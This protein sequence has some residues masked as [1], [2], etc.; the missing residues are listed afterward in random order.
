[1]M[2]IIY[3]VLLL[4]SIANLVSIQL[5]GIEGNAYYTGMKTV[6]I[7]VLVNL[8]V[9]IVQNI[10]NSKGKRNEIVG[11]FTLFLLAY[12]CVHFQTFT[13]LM[14][15]EDY[16]DRFNVYNDKY[17]NLRTAIISIIGLE[18]LLLGNSIALHRKTVSKLYGIKV[19]VSEGKKL[20]K[21]I[22]FFLF[23]S[24][25][26]FTYL[27][28]RQ[29]FEGV[30]S[31]EMLDNMSGTMNAYSGILVE[32]LFYSAVLFKI[33]SIRESVP[34]YFTFV[35]YLKSFSFLFYLS[36]LI[37]LVLVFIYGDR[38]PIISFVLS[39]G[40][41]YIMIS[42]HR[43]SWVTL[44]TFFVIGGMFLS[45]MGIARADRM[46]GSY[47]LQNT[48]N[49]IKTILDLKSVF[50]FT[51]ELAGSNRT[52]VW[53]VESTPSEYP[54]RNGL[55]SLNHIIGIIPFSGTLLKTMGINI[56]GSNHY[57]HSSSFLN[58]YTQGDNVT[59]GVGTSTVADIYLDFGV[60]GVVIVLFLLGLFFARIDKIMMNYSSNSIP[61]LTM[62]TCLVFFSSSV[63]LAR[64]SI[65]PLFRNV[66]WLYVL[67]TVLLKTNIVKK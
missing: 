50:P 2:S 49:N 15:F 43:F 30:Y 17:I 39:M 58:W 59:A 4:Y 9:L 52:A 24:V 44:L 12:L 46:E 21:R 3:I 23:L 60:P 57:G 26:L 36:V 48:E 29:Y 65:I 19:L 55:F 7:L 8:L 33:Y 20:K 67:M 56:N 66:V 31:Q 41:G 5:N 10:I 1:M 62:I 18:A 22:D 25:L 38:G 6:L 16:E 53:A 64:S 32:L 42:K 27:N 14:A 34:K 13:N 11:V 37:Y 35:T 45:V 61:L 40:F 47:N 28:G 63:Y 54:Y 51:E